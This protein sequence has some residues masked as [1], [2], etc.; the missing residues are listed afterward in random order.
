MRTTINLDG[1]VLD[2]AKV[3][4]E[5][6]GKSFRFVVNEA[7]RSGLQS[8]GK[9]GEGKRFRTQPREMGLREGVS[10][11]NIGELLERLEEGEKRR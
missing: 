1:D 2:R 3:L 7:M 10:L 4:A 6:M 11:D 5:R 8:L 9:S